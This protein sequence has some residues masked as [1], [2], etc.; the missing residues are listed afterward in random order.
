MGGGEG[1][2]GSQGRKEQLTLCLHSEPRWEDGV[3]PEGAWNVGC[4][5]H[6]C[7][8]VKCS[9]VGPFEVS[10]PSDLASCCASQPQLV[11]SVVQTGIHPF[12]LKRKGGGRLGGGT[13]LG[14]GTQK[15]LS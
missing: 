12:R 13:K 9:G 3:Y 1:D 14:G 10:L 6:M 11:L 8:T 4:Q 2:G 7:K 5:S 15:V